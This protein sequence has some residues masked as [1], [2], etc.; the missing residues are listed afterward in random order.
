MHLLTENHKRVRKTRGGQ[1]AHKRLISDM[2]DFG[3]QPDDIK[4][5]MA[6]VKSFVGVL[7]IELMWENKMGF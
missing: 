4:Q 3:R 6:G 2:A 7:E 5:P 1:A